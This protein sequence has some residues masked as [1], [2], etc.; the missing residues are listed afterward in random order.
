MLLKTSTSHEEGAERKWL[1]WLR[2][3]AAK[4]D[5]LKKLYLRGFV[6]KDAKDCPIM[7]EAP[8]S[9]FEIETD[10]DHIAVGFHPIG[11]PGLLKN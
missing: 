3:S 1:S 4:T 10:R 6:Q 2:N 11:A 5:G 8:G 9:E 7:K